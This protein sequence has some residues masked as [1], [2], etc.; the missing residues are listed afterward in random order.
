M[1]NAEEELKDI[2]GFSENQF[3]SNLDEDPSRLF[4]K[5]TSKLLIKAETK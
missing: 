1:E 4:F 5:I 2:S 3:F